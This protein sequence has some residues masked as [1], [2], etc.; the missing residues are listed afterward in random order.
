MKASRQAGSLLPLALWVVTVWMAADVQG[1]GMA[2]PLPAAAQDSQQLQ[3]EKGRM[4]VTQL[5]VGCHNGIMR[6]LEIREK[7]EE[8]WRDTVHSMIGRGAQILPDEIEPITAFLVANAG[9]GR[10]QASSPASPA[11]AGQSATE[12]SAI[13]TRRCEQCHDLERATTRTSSEDWP[14][15]IDRMMSLGASLTPA[16][17]RT[18][19]EY[20]TGLE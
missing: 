18:L 9:Q 6:M 20:L 3:I 17:Q 10:P 11:G 1:T 14:T 5:C 15:I 16:E 19:L 13:L 2:A 12:A 8:E 4:A 7:S